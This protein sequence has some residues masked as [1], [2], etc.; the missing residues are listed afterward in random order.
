MTITIFI[1]FREIKSDEINVFSFVYVLLGFKYLI[2]CFS[3]LGILF[4][5][6]FFY[7]DIDYETI[8][9][10]IH[11][12]DYNKAYVNRKTIFHYTHAFSNSRTICNPNN[13]WER[14]CGVYSTS[15]KTA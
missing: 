13:L 10:P 6:Q 5:D 9:I 11:Q 8:K 1:E 14:A 3:I 4:V 15:K 7:K 12:Y 2:L